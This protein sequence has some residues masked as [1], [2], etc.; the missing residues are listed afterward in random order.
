MSDDNWPLA[1]DLLCKA[2]RQIAEAYDVSLCCE[3]AATPQEAFDRVMRMGL[4]AATEP[5]LAVYEALGGVG[6]PNTEGIVVS[7]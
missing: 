1:M 5:A 4:I 2:G 6:V 7:Y 3:P